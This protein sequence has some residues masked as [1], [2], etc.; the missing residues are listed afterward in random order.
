MDACLEGGLEP[1][2]GEGEGEEES[3][4]DRLARYSDCEVTIGDLEECISTKVEQ[5]VEGVKAL[6][7]VTCAEIARAI[8]QGEES[9]PGQD[10]TEPPALCQEIEEEC[11]GITEDEKTTTPPAEPPE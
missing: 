1:S 10:K 4:P 8:E 2:E 7:L 6:G 3:C 11:P 9:L 5:Q